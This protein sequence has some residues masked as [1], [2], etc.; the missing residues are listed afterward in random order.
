MS[1]IRNQVRIIGNLG[2][3]PL[4]RQTNNGKSV[5]NFPVATN[6]TYV[7]EAG[8]KVNETQ[9][10]QVVCW[11]KLANLSLELLKK[12]MEV[13]VEGKISNRSY[14]D[15]DGVK[16]NVSEVIAFDFLLV[17]RKQAEAA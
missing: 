15:K 6:E 3:D 16:R 13:V 7:N 5:T 4:E 8:E 11:G 17:G 12:G 9:W 1:H 2:A 10:H 14:V